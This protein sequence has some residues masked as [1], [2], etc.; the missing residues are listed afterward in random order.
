MTT[1]NDETAVI[2]ALKETGDDGL[3]AELAAAA[4]KRWWNKGTVVLGVAALLMGGFLGGVQA[5]KQWGTTTT[6]AFPSGG[7]RGGFPGGVTASGAPRQTAARNTTGKVKL[8]NGKT[9]YIET[10][11]GTVVTVKTDGDTTVSTAAKGKLSDVK[12]GQSVT[13]E[14]ATAADGSVTATTVTATR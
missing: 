4:P 9:L 8:V 11:D 6:A 13:I 5:Q 14:G 12:A 7:M 2:P 1:L 10:A 3:S